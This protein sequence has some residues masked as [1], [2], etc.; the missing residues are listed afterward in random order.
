MRKEMMGRRLL[1]MPMVL[2]QIRT[3][4]DGIL[5]ASESI[6]EKALFVMAGV[7]VVLF[8]VILV[9]VTKIV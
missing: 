5:K 1:I 9:S 2:R 8:S 6:R 4:A 7:A 3:Q